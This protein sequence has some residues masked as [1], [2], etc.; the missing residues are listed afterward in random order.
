MKAETVFVCTQCGRT[1]VKWMGRCPGC[2]EW[3]TVVER[4]MPSVRSKAALSLAQTEPGG[5]LPITEIRGMP[6][7]RLKTGMEEFDR[8]L[9][10]GI[11]ARSLILLG[12]DPGIGKS[13]LLMQALGALA[14]LNERVLY[15]SGEESPE[16]LKLR[17]DRLGILADNFL[18]LAENRFETVLSHIDE[19]QCSVVVVDSVQSIFSPSLDS[20]AGSVS[21]IRHVTAG[22][23]DVV[24]RGAAACFL[25]GHVTKDGV[26]AGPKVLEHMVD[27]VL[28]F[29]GER[30]HPY[31]ILRASKN[32][33]GSSSEIGVFEMGDRGLQEVA[34]PSELF[35]SERPEGVSG[36]AV[37]ALVE[38]TRP[39]LAEIQALVTGPAP[40]Q[41]RRTCLG[42]DSQRLALMIAVLEKKLGLALA[43][44][45]IFLN[46][47][48]GVRASEPAADL[49]VAGAL[50]SSFMDRVAGS[51]T[52]LFGEVGLAGEARRV[53]N[54]EGRIAEAARLGFTRIIAPKA[55]VEAAAPGRGLKLVAI[56]HI[57]ELASL[58][59]QEES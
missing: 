9:G 17:A 21:Q 48:G 14:R 5:V 11:V 22:I 3:N 20:A 19:S 36:S 49:A 12:G 58:L 1:L 44:Q 7:A 53:S 10:G 13:T 56:T 41:G 52:V 47:V 26:L 29:E 27:T 32:R 54:A 30:S 18:V 15:I 59:F 4:D 55:N 51:R 46:A 57:K 23:L 24:K 45:D 40:G 2:G 25:V 31:R 8:A 34:N 6:E 16:Q 35:L 28:S 42:V 37:T 50:L 33:F 43:D 39:I 38:G